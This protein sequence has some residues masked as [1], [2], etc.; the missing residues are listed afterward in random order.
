MFESTFKVSDIYTDFYKAI[1]PVLFLN[2]N[3]RYIYSFTDHN[4]LILIDMM[5][6]GFTHYYKRIK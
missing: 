3:P 5:D 4:N 6:D 1:S 2:A